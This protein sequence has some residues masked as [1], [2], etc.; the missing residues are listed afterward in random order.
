MAEQQDQ[1]L[2]TL[3]SGR[4][5]KLESDKENWVQRMQDVADYV[6]PH[7]DDIRGT[8]VSGE[9]KGTKIYDGTA[10]GAAVLATDGIHG[11]HVSPAFPWF[12]YIMSRK[13]ANEIKEIRLWLEEVEY[14]MYMA[15]TRSN[16]YSEMWSFIFDG[17][18]IATAAMYSEEDL[19]EGRIVFEA[20]HP[21]EL[22]IAENQ[23][24][25]VDVLHR[26]RKLSARKLVQM[27]GEDNLPEA[28]KINNKTQPFS[29]FEIIHATFPREEYDNRIKNAK[30]KKFASIWMLTEGNHICRVSGFDQFPY[31]VWRYLRTGKDPYGV[32]PAHL[33]MAD[34]KGVNLMSKTLQGAAQLAVDPAYNVPSHLQGK[35]QLKPRGL[36]YMDEPGQAITPVNTSSNYPVGIDREQAK[37]QSI[38]ERF[39]VDTF[40]MLTQ[41]NAQPGARTAFEVSEMM[42]EK[43][44]VLGAELGPLNAELD[45]ILDQVYNIE[46]AAGRISQPPDILYDMVDQDPSLRFDPVYQGPLA[47]AQREK[48][49][50]DS[51]RKFFLDIG[52]LMEIDETVVD[53]FDLDKSSRILAD[54]NGIPEDIKRDVES[55]KK[56]REGRAQAQ[57][58]AQQQEDA[59]A[60]VQGL[61]TASEA[62]KN[63]GGQLSSA[64]AGGV[65]GT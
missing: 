13:A 53:N 46:K 47:Q 52:P 15:L 24:G 54:V 57:I 45:N 18:T 50:K 55:V 39:H 59:E 58:E 62:D 12:K 65:P 21:G 31:N 4:Q 7:R 29:E 37:Q 8:L 11:Y 43:A 1:E 41:L 9:R 16:F 64:L 56:I 61:K 19:A 35:V 44:A 20:V 17:F 3:V 34:I 60:M 10:Q 5:S 14:A 33:A 49:G 40:L 48:F 25:E 23:Y 28:I 42:A 63:L 32:S 51:I 2:K 27:F 38:K 36:N 30:N 26:K 22:Y 6:I